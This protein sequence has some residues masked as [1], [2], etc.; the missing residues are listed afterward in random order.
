LSK[1]S[2]GLLSLGQ[3]QIL[4]LTELNGEK[5]A[6]DKIHARAKKVAASYKSQRRQKTTYIFTG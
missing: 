5:R 1:D 2:P 6:V 4:R 3:K